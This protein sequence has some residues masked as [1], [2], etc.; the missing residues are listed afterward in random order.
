MNSNLEA[1]NSK[2]ITLIGAVVAM[3]AYIYVVLRGYFVPPFCDEIITFF[4]Y[5]RTGDMHPFYAKLDANN[6]VLNSAISRVFYLLFGGEIFVLR[7]ANL[8]AFGGYLFYLFR[9][10]QFFQKPMIS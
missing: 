1:S 3:L 10:K 2:C 5:V 8:L 6:H 9:F 4:D 7:L